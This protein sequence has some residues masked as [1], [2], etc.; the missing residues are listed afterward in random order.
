VLNATVARYLERNPC[1]G[2]KF[3]VAAHGVGG[4]VAL[5]LMM[6][7]K[8]AIL[9]A[10]AADEPPVAVAAVAP[11]PAPAAPADGAPVFPEGTSVASVLAE[12]G[13][14]VAVFVWRPRL[15][16]ARLTGL[17]E[18]AGKLA[19]EDLD[20]PALA[21]CSDA[22]LKEL[23]LT[24]GHRKKVLAA[25]AACA[26]RGAQEA[27][28]R[29]QLLAQQQQAQEAQQR[30]ASVPTSAWPLLKFKTG[31]CFLLGAPIGP[32]ACLFVSFLF[33]PNPWLVC[34]ADA[35]AAS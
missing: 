15:T 5:D 13:G 29:A 7:Q 17:G 10:A 28:A 14:F 27:A 31:C 24:L 22:E 18:V 16:G 11:A 9:A 20:L 6:G 8:D 12:I 19:Q 33:G 23:G 4:A 2:G 35:G 21:R 25:V 32:D 3:H 34:S 30:A 1:F 26:A